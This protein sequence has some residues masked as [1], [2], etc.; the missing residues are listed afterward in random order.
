MILQ[1]MTD[2]EA[3]VEALCEG[4]EF[5]CLCRFEG[6]RLLDEDVLARL[7]RLLRQG[8]MQRRRGRDGDGVD[9]GVSERFLKSE[10]TAAVLGD[11][12][13]DGGPM[14]VDERFEGPEL[15]EIADE[16]LPQ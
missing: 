1:E 12:G 2:H 5:L 13:V 16:F 8:V 6:E 4:A 15:G 14:R 11:E 10:R 7:E 3:P 9:R